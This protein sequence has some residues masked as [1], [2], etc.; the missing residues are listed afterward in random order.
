MKIR[1]ACCKKPLTHETGKNDGRPLFKG[2]KWAVCDECNE[3]Y[4]GPYREVLYDK[5]LHTMLYFPKGRKKVVQ[6][7]PLDHKLSYN[8]LLSYFNRKNADPWWIEFREDWY[9]KQK[10]HGDEVKIFFDYNHLSLTK[11]RY[12]R[13]YVIINDEDIDAE[14][15]LLE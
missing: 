11:A 10:F 2:K 13:P 1:C 5:F 3:K 12:L 4:V 8:E 6:F 7:I 15:F 9:Q 14:T